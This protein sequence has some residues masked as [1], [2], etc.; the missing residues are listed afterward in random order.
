MVRN[1]VISIIA[2]YVY[3]V[4]EW[5]FFVTKPSMF[6]L[7]RPVERFAILIVSSLPLMLVCVAGTFLLGIA[8]S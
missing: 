1:I 6:S 7:V 8:D 2:S 5:L 3:M 4:L